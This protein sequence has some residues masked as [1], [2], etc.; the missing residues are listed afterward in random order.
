M[1]FK[2]LKRFPRDLFFV[3]RDEEADQLFWKNKI[4]GKRGFVKVTL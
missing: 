3:Y 4:F 1:N 2:S